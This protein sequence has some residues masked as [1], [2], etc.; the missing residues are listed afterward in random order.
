VGLPQAGQSARFLRPDAENTGG[1]EAAAVD[2]V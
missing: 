1:S 2:P